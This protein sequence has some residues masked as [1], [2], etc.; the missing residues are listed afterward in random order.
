MPP[1]KYDDI[2]ALDLLIEQLISNQD[3]LKR[4]NDTILTKI[5]EL[6]NKLTEVRTRTL[7]Y[8]SALAVII[9]IFASLAKSAI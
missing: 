9:S 6:E 1:S 5:N 4:Q 3:E 7:L 8:G 2:S